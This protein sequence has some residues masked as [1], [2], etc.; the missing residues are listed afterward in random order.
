MAGLFL[1]RPALNDS[2]G[3]I[4]SVARLHGLTDLSVVKSRADTK[5]ICRARHPEWGSVAVKAL[6]PILNSKG[7]HSAHYTD[8][9]TAA[10]PARFLP[11]VYA[12]GDGYSITEW[13]DGSSLRHL[14]RRQR[15]GLPV[16]EFADAI[17]SWCGNLSAGSGL[18]PGHVGS[19]LRFYVQTTIRRM[20]YHGASRC[21][22]ACAAFLRHQRRLGQYID[23][24]VSLIPELR[25]Q[26]TP[27]FS[28]VQ[29]SNVLYA[30]GSDRLVLIDHEGL[31]HG[32]YLFDLA[33][34]FGSLLIYRY[35]PSL[36]GSFGNH[37]FGGTHIP[38]GP[39]E[40]FFRRFV[41]YVV[42]AYMTIDGRPRSAIDE[43]L[44]VIWNAGDAA[45]AEAER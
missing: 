20:N 27:M 42:E 37:L 31:K 21:L 11:R 17:R 16:L 44:G 22:K 6:D 39:P 5:V 41:A 29:V 34:F 12:R 28:D 14:D 2:L 1:R 25:L 40:E 18:E 33:F 38:L 9:L 26:A 19:I 15:Q 45:L 13:I 4:H 7:A 10:H 23:D 32:N 30:D 43:N 36:T 35:P 8:G 24:M 3:H